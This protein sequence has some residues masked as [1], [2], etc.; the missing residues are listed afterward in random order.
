[1]PTLVVRIPD[2]QV[3]NPPTP[4]NDGLNLASR[5]KFRER[6]ESS[7][8]RSRRRQRADRDDGPPRTE[9][10]SRHD[11]PDR[12]RRTQPDLHPRPARHPVAA[13]LRGPGRYR[14]RGLNPDPGADQA[15]LPARPR[16]R[17]PAQQRPAGLDPD[18]H[19]RRIRRDDDRMRCRD[20]ARTGRPGRR[21]LGAA[22]DRDLR[23]RADG[24]RAAARRPGLRFRPGGARGQGRPYQLARGRA[25]D[26]G[27]HR[28]HRPDRGVLRR[29]PLLQ[30]GATPWPGHLLA[31]QRPGLPGRVRGRDHR[32]GFQ[33]H[34]AAVLRRRA[35]RLDLDRG[36]LRPPLPPR[37]RRTYWHRARSG[38]PAV[39]IHPGIQRKY[40]ENRRKK[41]V[42]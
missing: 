8:R 19:L 15:R 36:D 24:R 16:R 42:T 21:H 1:M 6:V 25:P 2:R 9:G 38:R 13:R 12:R 32:I 39:D 20:A 28:V 17:E 10:T 27:E 7:S 14:L 26:L 33:R 4:N 18:R 30:P 37:R 34:R 31:R 29:G 35:H 5:K 11:H 40:N 22:A 23:R 41:C 3:Q